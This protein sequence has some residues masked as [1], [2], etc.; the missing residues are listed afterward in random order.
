MHA[1]RMNIEDMLVMLIEPS[2]MQR[3]IIN[4]HLNDLGVRDVLTADSAENAMQQ[5]LGSP[6]DLVISAL[7]LPDKEGTELL[8]EMRNSDTLTE[9]AFLLI[10]SE[11]DWRILDPIRQAG[12][13][14]TG[15]D[16]PFGSFSK[17]W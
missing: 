12:S 10:S 6:P 8:H 5:M 15:T 4:K 1:D 14:A 3:K 13:I 17:S 11:T 16:N 9:A 2:S 7:Y